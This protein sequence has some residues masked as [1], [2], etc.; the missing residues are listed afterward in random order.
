[1]TKRDGWVGAF[2]K[3][4]LRGH[5]GKDKLHCALAE[6]EDSF[7]NGGATGIRCG[8]MD[9]SACGMRVSFALMT[10]CDEARTIVQT[11][12]YVAA[13]RRGCHDKRCHK[14]WR[15]MYEHVVS[16]LVIV[17]RSGQHIDWHNAPSYA[18]AHALSVLARNVMS[19]RLAVRTVR[20]QM[21]GRWG[22]CGKLTVT[23]RG[24]RAVL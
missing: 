17:E 9:A 8:I 13:A 1:M 15:P 23:C 3:A 19:L 18:T 6:A 20:Y 7:D 22:L 10:R 4:G 2:D 16:L 21:A 24:T 11:Y 14:N 5:V 12:K